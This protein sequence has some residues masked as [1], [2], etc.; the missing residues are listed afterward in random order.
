MRTE[1]LSGTSIP[2]KLNLNVFLF[3]ALMKQTGE[4]QF[5]CTTAVTE[6]AQSEFIGK[7]RNIAQ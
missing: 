2:L 3:Y 4:Y 1:G 6:N 5:N 7:I